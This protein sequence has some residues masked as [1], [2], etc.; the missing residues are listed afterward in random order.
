[1]KVRVLS[2]TH[3]ETYI[4]SEGCDIE[5]VISR[6]N[7]LVHQVDPE[8]VLILPGDLGMVVSMEENFNCYYE[9]LLHYFKSRWNYII[10]VPGNT[11]YHGMVSGETLPFTENMLEKKCKE[12]GII[13]L[14]KG[15]VKIDDLFFVGCTLWTYPTQKEWKEIHKTDKKIFKEMVNYRMLHVEHLEWLND[16]LQ[17]LENQNEKAV[18]ISH[19]PPESHNK[20]PKIKKMNHVDAF[21]DKHSKVI[22]MWICGHIHDKHHLEKSGVPVYVNSM[23]ESGEYHLMEPGLIEI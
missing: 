16:I 7:D 20:N 5:K 8:E 12:M 9:K 13:Y 23:G 4:T 14:Q 19:Y 21:V 11:E 10:I 2:D 22:K 15:V 18:V 6:I 1:M 17:E 3:L